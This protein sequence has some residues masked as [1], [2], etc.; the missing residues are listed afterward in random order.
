MLCIEVVI[1]SLSLSLPP[2]P[3]P[4]PPHILCLAASSWARWFTAFPRST[5][6]PPAERDTSQV[7]LIPLISY[8]PQPP[9]SCGLEI[10]G[11]SP[12]LR[13]AQFSERLLGGARRRRGARE[14]RTQI[15]RAVYYGWNQYR[16]MNN[17]EGDH[18]LLHYR[19]VLYC[20]IDHS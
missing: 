8:L 15:R 5:F 14:S 2:P 11:G 12:S 1:Y 4:P 20:Q 18:T 10:D 6:N 19:S 17:S 7:H 3:P 9:V 16:D 13:S